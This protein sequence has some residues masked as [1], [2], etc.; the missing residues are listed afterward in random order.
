MEPFLKNRKI[1]FT[2]TTRINKNPQKPILKN[3]LFCFTRTPTALN[4][5]KK[6][7]LAMST[8]SPNGICK[9]DLVIC[10]DQSES[11]LPEDYVKLQNFVTD[12]IRLF[13]DQGPNSNQV[14]VLAFD[15]L[16]DEIFAL[17]TYR[18]VSSEITAVNNHVQGAGTTRIDLC[19]KYSTRVNGLRNRNIFP[20]VLLVITDGQSSDCSNL[21]E[22]VRQAKN[23]GFAR[24]AVGIGCEIDESELRQ[25]AGN[26]VFL[27]ENFGSLASIRDDVVALFCTS[28]GYFFI[29]CFK[30]LYLCIFAR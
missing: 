17:N 9:I 25:I 26:N 5:Q 3:K 10:M 14:S 21:A 11:I 30:K 13:P 15:N 29:I 28:F 24:I 12:I 6:T 22:A 7:N 27:A 20:R 2:P 8:I 23:A 4:D 19:I 1:N 16:V 18:D